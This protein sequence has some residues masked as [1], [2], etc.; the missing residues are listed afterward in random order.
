MLDKLPT[1]FQGFDPAPH[2]V[3]AVRPEYISPYVL[4]MTATE[5]NAQEI[6]EPLPVEEKVK[7][8]RSEALQKASTGEGQGQGTGSAISQGC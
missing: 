4:K 2:E 8:E 6:A 1:K 3:T 5:E 7:K